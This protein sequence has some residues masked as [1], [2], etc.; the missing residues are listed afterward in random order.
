MGC[1][2]KKT[3]SHFLLYCFLDGVQQRRH[4]NLCPCQKIM[5][6]CKLQCVYH[7]INHLMSTDIIFNFRKGKYFIN[8][9]YPF[10]FYT[11]LHYTLIYM[12]NPRLP[13]LMESS[14]P[15][16]SLIHTSCKPLSLLLLF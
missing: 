3:R 4:R 10:H 16:D 13:A 12:F 9:P 15:Y 5:F 14:V 8:L 11:C 6:Q 1:L 2:K 7:D